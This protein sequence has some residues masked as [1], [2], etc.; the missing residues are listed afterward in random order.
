MRCARSTTQTRPA[1]E[2]RGSSGPEGGPELQTPMTQL[3]MSFAA[4]P[5]P[6][7]R[8]PVWPPMPLRAA[9]TPPPLPARRR[10]RRPEPT[11]AFQVVYVIGCGKTKKSR[12]ARAAELYTGNLFQACARHARANGDTWRILSGLHGMMRPERVIAPYDA[13]V[14]RRQREREWWAINAANALTADPTLR[15][16]FR[17]VCLAGEEYAAPL[18]AALE[19]RGIEIECPLRGMQVGERLRW[20]KERAS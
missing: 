2:E 3:V 4:L 1:A 18:R 13:R 11:P 10:A 17:V 5:A 8:L 14:P 20:L 12:R 16:G 15:G 19:R 7:P 9:L 6:I